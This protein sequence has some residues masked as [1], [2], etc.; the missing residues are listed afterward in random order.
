MDRPESF[1][2]PATRFAASRGLMP[3]LLA[4]S[5]A[6]CGGGGEQAAPPPA[7]PVTIAAPLVQDVVDWDDF[8]GRFEAIQSVEV[9]PRA[10]GYLQAVHFQDGQYVRAGQL[11]FTIDARPSQAQ[12]DQARA[13]LARAE[14]SAA[15][16]C[17][18]SMVKRSCPARTYWP[19][20]KCTA[21]R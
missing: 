2:M 11:L 7:M 9:K 1:K 10:T 12:L 16:D 3:F 18:G 5:L 6:A 8:V 15:W 17:L 4:L 14:A 20:W 19:S 21:W 13:Q